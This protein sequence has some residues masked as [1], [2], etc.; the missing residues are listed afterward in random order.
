[1]DKE[2]ADRKIE[3]ELEK[4]D[5]SWYR[6][7]IGPEGADYSDLDL[8]MVSKNPGKGPQNMISIRYEEI[9]EITAGKA[10]S[11]GSWPE[12]KAIIIRTERNSYWFLE[13]GDVYVDIR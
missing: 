10:G 3:R 8:Y 9:E 5:F 4:S 12:K 13:S 11:S 1:M 6:S 7:R 2:E